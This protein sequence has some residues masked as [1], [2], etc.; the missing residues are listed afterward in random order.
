MAGEVYLGRVALSSLLSAIHFRHFRVLLC[1]IAS[2][3][4]FFSN[5]KV[6]AKRKILPTTI[7]MASELPKK[8][9]AAIYDKPGSIST[10][11][12]DLDMPE[13]GAGEILVNLTH[14]GVCHS[15][16]GIMLNAW[17]TLPF[18]TQAGQVGGHEGVGNIVKMGP[19]TDSSAVKLGDRVGIKWMAGICE[20]CEAC[21]AG[22]DAQCFSGVSQ[23][24]V[25][26]R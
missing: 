12:V 10:K 23:V 4:Y 1:S 15:D 7:D 25:H 14:S 24:F 16:M 21:R 6:T 20:S 17:K 18:P 8:Y 13:P 26:R 9:K 11:I 2:L 19:G 3:L 5:S 22:C